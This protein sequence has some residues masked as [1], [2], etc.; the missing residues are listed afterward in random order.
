MRSNNTPAVNVALRIAAA[1]RNEDRVGH[2][3][4][5]DGI[6]ILAADGAGGLSGGGRAADLVLELGRRAAPEADL[7][8]LLRAVDLALSA[9]A[10]AG[11]ATGVIVIVRDAV[12]TGVSVGDSGA[13]MISPDGIV[14]LTA[15]QVRKPLL[16][17]GEAMPVAFGPLRLH[18]R[19]LV[20]T[21]GLFKYARR[22]AIALAALLPDLD[23]AADRL[24]AAP[25][26]PSGTLQDDV[27]LALVG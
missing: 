22:D 24:L 3:S 11:E 19:L 6:G 25:R 26:L 27:G 7:V 20:A 12:V 17:S 21:D 8:K 23:E 10:L 13:W 4:Y 9:D 5:A 15:A 2:W 1:G 16:G 18:G 14:D